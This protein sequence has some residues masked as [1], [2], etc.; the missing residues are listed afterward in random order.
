[1]DCM[2]CVCV[3]AI[4]WSVCSWTSSADECGC[5][6]SVDWLQNITGPG[7]IGILVTHLAVSIL[8]ASD[9]GQVDRLY[10]RQHQPV[11]PPSRSSHHHLPVS[12]SPTYVFFMSDS[13]S[14]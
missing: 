7:Y 13:E 6:M 11:L 1:M 8:R 3:Y 14:I 9:E 2:S 10:L 4:L 5:L 12:Q